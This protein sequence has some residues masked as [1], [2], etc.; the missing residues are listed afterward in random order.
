MTRRPRYIELFA[1]GGGL[2]LGLDR[3]GFE[4]AAHAEIDAGARSVLKHRWPTTPLYGD[5]AQLTGEQLRRDL[6]D[7]DILTGG[8][9][10][11]G[12][13]RAGKM[14][15]LSDSR[16]A[17]FFQQVRIWNELEAPYILWEN[18]DGAL[19]NE[20]GKDFAVVLSTIVGARVVIPDGGWDSG[21]VAIGATAVAAWR[22]LDSQ[23]F[24]VAQRRARVFILGAR[25][26]GLDPA[27]VLLEPE[28]L[29]GNSKPRRAAQKRFAS[30]TGEGAPTSSEPEVYDARGNGD[31]RIAPSITGDHNNRVTDYTAII[32]PPEPAPFNLA[33]ITSRIHKQRVESGRP[34]PTLDSKGQVGVIGFHYKQ[35]PI[36]DEISPAL[37]ATSGGMAVVPPGGEED[38]TDQATF[39]MVAFGK[40]SDDGTASALKARDYKDATDLIIQLPFTFKPSHFTRGKDGAPSDILPPLTADA[41]K[42]DQD[43]LIVGTL[44]ARHAGGFQ[45]AQAAAGGHLLAP[46]GTPRRLTPRE[47]ERLQSWPDDWTLVPDEKGKPL[48][49][50]ARYRIAGLGVTSNVAE[51]IGIRFREVWERSL[52]NRTDRD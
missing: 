45:S 38:A 5:V 28:S 3:A 4:C 15:G 20:G 46:M 41:D 13:S 33:Q 7:V 23:F 42:G 9:P 29:R 16:S 31:G 47:C 22:V 51:W 26:G 17:L 14:E 49:D 2:S 27:Q 24:G 36:S 18:V 19:S 32:T 10:C 6:G 52:P 44:Q 35:D 11:Q 8:S 25:T 30:G 21:G 39:R 1:G 48:S 40:Y 37:G 43:P 50:S 12:L 34:T